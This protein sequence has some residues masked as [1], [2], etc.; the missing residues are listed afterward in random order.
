M[1]VLPP[2][3]G[4]AQ[5]WHRCPLSARSG[6]Q[7]SFFQELLFGQSTSGSRSPVARLRG[8]Q[9][10]HGLLPPI[11][12]DQARQHSGRS[13]SGGAGS[14]G[15]GHSWPALS[16]VTIVDAFS[17]QRL[18]AAPLAFGLRSNLLA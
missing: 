17:P 4:H 14:E 9:W 15:P 6:R 1:S 10:S 5:R 16:D 2:K 12:P 8:A 18:T 3:S 7:G 13:R 11:V